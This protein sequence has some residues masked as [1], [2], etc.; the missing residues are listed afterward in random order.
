MKTTET[1]NIKRRSFLKGAAVSTVAVS[2][3]A[4]AGNAVAEG[5]PKAPE[6]PKQGY[7]LT[8]HVK[9]YYRLARF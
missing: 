8:R 9:D 7:Q 6:K 5:A 2:S 3:A 4:V 1:T